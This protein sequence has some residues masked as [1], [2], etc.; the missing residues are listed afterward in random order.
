MRRI[1]FVLVPGLICSAPPIDFPQMM[2]DYFLRNIERHAYSARDHFNLIL[3]RPCGS[4]DWLI[5]SSKHLE[6]EL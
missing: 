6:L 3:D 4:F 2:Q 1:E 5:T